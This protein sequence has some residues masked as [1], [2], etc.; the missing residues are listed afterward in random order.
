MQR[1]L[2]ERV[3]TTPSTPPTPAV[4]I[5]CR[6]LSNGKRLQHT[7]RTP[8]HVIHLHLR[9][10]SYVRFP[11]PPAPLRLII[12]LFIIVRVHLPIGAV[13]GPPT[14]V[15]DVFANGVS[16]LIGASAPPL[17]SPCFRSPSL[18]PLHWCVLVQP[19]VPFPMVFFFATG[20]W[21]Q[22]NFG[23]RNNLG[24]PGKPGPGH[25]GLYHARTGST[26]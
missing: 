15:I 11:R 24:A 21:L 3:S 26:C 16:F 9:F 12:L 22:L 18:L 25:C 17:C 14:D 2:S 23:P 7:L 4:F 20:R 1:F 5:Q 6:L 10:C 8:T 13:C 19:R